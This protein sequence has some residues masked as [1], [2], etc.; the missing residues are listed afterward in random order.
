MVDLRSDTVTRPSDAMRAA[1]SQATVGDDVYSEDETVN[2]LQNHVARLC[3]KEAALFVPS[4]TQ[5]NL[6]GLGVHCER[7]SE[8]ILGSQA[9]VFYY[10]GGGASSHLGVAYNLQP[11]LAD[12]TMCLQG[13]EDCIRPLNDHYP[14]TALVAIENTHNKCGG[15]IISP[16]YVKALSALCKKHSLPLHLDGARLWN[17]SVA[18]NK[19]V[20]EL[21]ADIDTVSVCLSKGL[22]APIGSVLVGPAEYIRKAKRLRKSLGGGMRQAGILAAAGLYA[23]EHN[24]DR[25]ADD[26]KRAKA[27]ASALRR[28]SDLQEVPLE[29]DIDTNIVYFNVPDGKGALFARVLQKDHNVLLG[30]YGSSKVSCVRIVVWFKK[31]TR[32]KNTHYFTYQTRTTTLSLTCTHTHTR[33]HA[34][35]C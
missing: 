14:R 32:S 30:S 18:L 17:A 33:T 25:L 13:V 28:F 27:I 20:D 7:G 5:S 4:G 16:A 31:K 22:G 2:A 35:E 24:V 10:E 9:H 11:Q 29:A 12:G 19:P 1:M 34:H 15:K 23:L 21:V 8:V 3:G 26:H 6:I